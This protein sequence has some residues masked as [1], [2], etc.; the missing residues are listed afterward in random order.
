[1]MSGGPK[2]DEKLLTQLFGDAA[3]QV[4][5]MYMEARTD[6]SKELA[7]I[8]LMSDLVFRMPALRLA[9]RQVQQGA[10]VWMYRFDW[11]SPAFGGVLGAAHA[12]DIPFVF[13]TLTVGLARA[14]TGDSPDRQP[15]A[16]L[17]HAAWAA[18]I[19]RGNP[20]IARLPVWPPYDLDRRATMI[21][22]DAPYVVDDPQGPVRA[23]WKQVLQA[24]ES[25]A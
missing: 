4:L 24:R 19:R 11:A 21:F 2:V 23:L 20:A 10:L 8:D 9:E 22:S 6:G 3:Q 14:F 5:A 17:M 15:L 16:D 18:F 13:N 1:M 25:R 12:M 7:W